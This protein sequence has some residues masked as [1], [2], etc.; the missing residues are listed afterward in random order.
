MIMAL[1]LV[2]WK[3]SEGKKQQPREKIQEYGVESLNDSELLSAFLGT[4][5]KDLSVDQLSKHLLS[6]FGTRGLFQFS[7]LDTFQEATGLPFVKSCQLL[8]MGEYFRRLQRKDETCIKSS[9]QFYE[10]IRDDF[11]RTS[12]EQLRVVCLD[13]QRR[14]LYTGLIAQGS[15]NSISVTLASVFHHPIRLNAQSFYLAHNHPKGKLNP[16]QEDITFT[17]QIKRESEKFGLQF[18]D[19]LILGLEGFYSFALKGAI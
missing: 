12:F 19:H 11:K 8:A 10:Y 7:K 13:P 3:L 18:E 6:Q 17:L 15:A 16:S 2:K 5:Y 14:V 9:E 4:G 1:K